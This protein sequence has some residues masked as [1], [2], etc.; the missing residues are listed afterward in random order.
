MYLD[1]HAFIQLS[2]YYTVSNIIVERAIVNQERRMAHISNCTFKRNSANEF[3]AAVC[4]TSTT[5]LVESNNISL[6]TV[7]DW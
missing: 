4:L 1:L 7:L 6:I 2:I 5:F 3:G